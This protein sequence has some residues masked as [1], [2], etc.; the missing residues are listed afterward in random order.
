MRQTSMRPLLIFALAGLLLTGCAGLGERAVVSEKTLANGLRVIVREDHRSPVVV[1]QIW[2]K[3]GSQD[4][5]AGLTGISHALEHMMFKGT[6]KLGPNEFSRIIAANGGRENAF[7]SYDYT[8]YFQQLEK[9]R[10]PVAFE[11][12]ADR[13]RNL[14]LDPEEFGREIKVVMEERRLRTEDEPDALLYEKFMNTAYQVHSYRNPIIGWMPDLENM[15]AMDMREWY[16]RWYAPNNA[17]LVVAGDVNPGEVFLQAEEYFGPLKAES[18]PHAVAPVEPKQQGERRTSVSVP[19]EVPQIVMGY[20]V[21]VM[22]PDDADWEPYA[23]TVLAGVLDGGD[24]ARFRK[25]LVREQK[26]ASDVD[27]GYSMVSRAPDL[28][29]L[30][31]TPAEG[32]TVA[33]LEEALRAQVKRVREQPVSEAELRRIKAQVVAADVYG[34]DS[35]FN[36]AM[37]IGRLAAVGLDIRLL[38]RYVERIDAVTAEQVRVVARKYLRDDNVTV[39]VLDPLP[40]A[41]GQRRS[42]VR[43]GGSHAH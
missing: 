38:D 21:P 3:V 12:E 37:Q 13:M 39:A 1:S 15:K 35:V 28:F 4:E 34:R 2:Y 16:R 23:L 22:S 41:K 30:S 10:L 26:V 24:S 43:T 36:L 18:L 29:S 8:A 14:R 19:A 31:G 40:I 33:Q 27:A 9:S 32:R 6:A 5:P 25:E 20:H 7:T 42:P 17:I 11:L